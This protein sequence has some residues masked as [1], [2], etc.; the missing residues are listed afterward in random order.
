MIEQQS[1]EQI[2]GA[3]PAPVAGAIGAV[4][5]PAMDLSQV[6]FKSHIRPD[7]RAFL[8]ISRLIIWFVILLTLIPI[9]LIAIASFTAGNAGS[10]SQLI[11][12]HFTFDHYGNVFDPK[13]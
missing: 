13:I 7:E 1:S 6:R 3:V 12:Q 9:V 11:P 2:S 8:W 10:A 5:A 4:A